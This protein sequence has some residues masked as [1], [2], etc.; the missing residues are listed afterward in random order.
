MGP[1]GFAAGEPS[2]SLLPLVAVDW[3]GVGFLTMLSDL[4]VFSAAQAGTEASAATTIKM[5]VS[6]TIDASMDTSSQPVP[7][8]AAR[9]ETPTA[10]HSTPARSRVS[11]LVVPSLQPLADLRGSQ[12]LQVPR[13]Q[14]AAST[15]RA[16]A[17]A[18]TSA[19]GPDR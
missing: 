3:T 12:L 11:I 6:R 8:E 5:T 7:P 9:R 18:E 19:V 2:G 15:A 17:S 4:P 16:P 13:T 10:I 1:A 14:L